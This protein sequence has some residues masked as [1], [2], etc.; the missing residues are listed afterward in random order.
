MY[1]FAE[2]KFHSLPKI[3]IGF[4]ISQLKSYSHHHH[5]SL[6]NSN[7]TNTWRSIPSSR[8]LQASLLVWLDSCDHN[9]RGS[10]LSNRHIVIAREF[11]F[12]T[13][14]HHILY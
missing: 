8:N 5:S 4:E 14:A 6:V 9:H 10:A 13:V 12:A 1:D 3:L 2:P 11:N 7:I